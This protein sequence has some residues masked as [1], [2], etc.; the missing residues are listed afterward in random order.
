MLIDTSSIPMKTSSWNWH[1]SVARYSSND[2]I[3]EL[4]YSDVVI[5]GEILVLDRKDEAT[6]F[7]RMKI[8][9]LHDLDGG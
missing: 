5:S 3:I 4:C 2:V 9:V 6:F 7:N 8:Y 1:R